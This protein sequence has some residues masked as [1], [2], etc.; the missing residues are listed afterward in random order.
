VSLSRKHLIKQIYIHRS[1]SR[2]LGPKDYKIF[3][4]LF[5]KKNTKLGTKVNIHLG[6]LPEP[7]N[8][9]V[10]VRDPEA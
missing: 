3:G 2:F 7:W 4:G 6:P 1:R 9:P 5:V 10:Q 8:R